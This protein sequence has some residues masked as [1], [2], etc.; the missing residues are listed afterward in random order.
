M[1]IA[2]VT[3]TTAI[4]AIKMSLGLFRSSARQH[5]PQSSPHLT[6]N[7]LTPILSAPC[8]KKILLMSTNDDELNHSW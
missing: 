8:D 2:I 1:V 7:K 6:H 3:M 5:T 4:D